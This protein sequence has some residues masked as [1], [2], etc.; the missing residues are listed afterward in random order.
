MTVDVRVYGGPSSATPIPTFSDN[1]NRIAQWIQGTTPWQLW[2]TGAQFRSNNAPPFTPGPQQVLIGGGLDCNGSVAKI[3]SAGLGV[4]F[5]VRS[6]IVPGVFWGVDFS[7]VTSSSGGSGGKSQFSQFK[8][9]AD[10]SVAFPVLVRYG[11]GTLCQL[12]D[13]LFVGIGGG[14]YLEMQLNDFAGAYSGTLALYRQLGSGGTGTG[15]TLLATSAAGVF[16][17][18]DTVRLETTVNAGNNSNVVKVNGATVLGP[19]VDSDA[20]RPKYGIP[21]IGFTFSIGG[22]FATIDDYQGGPL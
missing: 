19:T 10:T 15:G 12:N 3:Q 16:N 7:G 1:F 14:Y 4:S 18:G 6:W 17:V 21:G 9:V 5:Q 13:P 8:L 11:L 20:A 2:A 22:A